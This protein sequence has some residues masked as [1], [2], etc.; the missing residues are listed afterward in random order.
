MSAAIELPAAP[1]SRGVYSGGKPL[2]ARRSGDRWVLDEDV[3]GTVT[4]EVR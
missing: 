3:A 1:G 4:L 2:R